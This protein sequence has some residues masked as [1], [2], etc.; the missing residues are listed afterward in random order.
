MQVCFS[1]CFSFI[2]KITGI[3][4]S[5][6]FS[7]RQ[8]DVMASARGGRRRSRDLLLGGGSNI[9]GIQFSGDPTLRGGS[10]A[11]RRPQLKEEGLVFGGSNS[12]RIQLLEDPTWRRIWLPEEDLALREGSG[13]QRIQL[14]E[15]P[16]LEGSSSQRR[17]GHSED[18]A[19]RRCNSWRTQLSANP[20][21]GARGS[22]RRMQC[23]P[24]RC[25]P[26]AVAGLPRGWSRSRPLL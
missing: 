20:T 23:S 25:C 21:L 22:W 12:Q 17:I 6:F 19:F 4:L 1:F 16:V 26:S 7:F 15:D 10:A 18:P 13:A 14:L 5:F 11:W 9:H 24:H 2:K 8:R 3:K